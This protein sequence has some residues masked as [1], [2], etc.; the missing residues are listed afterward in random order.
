MHTSEIYSLFCVI[1]L[2][3]KIRKQNYSVTNLERWKDFQIQ[4]QKQFPQ[5]KSILR[6]NKHFKAKKLQINT[7]HIYTYIYQREWDGKTHETWFGSAD[8]AR[9]TRRWVC[10]CVCAKWRRSKKK[11]QRIRIKLIIIEWGSE[12]TETVK[13]FLLLKNMKRKILSLQNNTQRE[14]DHYCVVR[15]TVILF[16]INY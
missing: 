10:V 9:R 3:E 12:H 7:R 14:E 8:A 5:V 16:F 6:A 1:F 13:P 4:N 15:D 2:R 11:K